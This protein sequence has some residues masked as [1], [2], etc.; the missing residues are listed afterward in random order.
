MTD[1]TNG[2]EGVVAAPGAGGGSDGNSNRR[3]NDWDC[4]NEDCDNVCFSFRTSCNRCGTGK[5]GTLPP[6][7]FRQG[8]GGGQGG[9]LDGEPVAGTLHRPRLQLG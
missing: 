2:S 9:G 5:D 7:D 4:P 6:K 1:N 3:A 8:G